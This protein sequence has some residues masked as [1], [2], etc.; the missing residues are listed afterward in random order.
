MQKLR[1]KWCPERGHW[2]SEDL[3]RVMWSDE[4]CYTLF[5]SDGKYRIWREPHKAMNP[6]CL[7]RTVCSERPNCK[8]PSSW[9][10]CV[11]E[12]SQ[13]LGVSRRDGIFQDDIAPIHVS[14]LVQSW[15]DEHENEVKYLPWPTKS[16]H[17]NRIE[18]LWSI[19]ERS[20]PNRYPSLASL[21]RIFPIPP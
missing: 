6:F 1:F 18:P 15:F 13:L 21:P 11:T 14:G 10:K 20:K 8:S 12:T 9:S 16:P 19:S 7:T 3:K 2:T 4:P 17:L 5:C